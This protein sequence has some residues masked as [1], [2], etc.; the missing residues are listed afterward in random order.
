MDKASCKVSCCCVSALEGLLACSAMVPVI[1][2]RARPGPRTKMDLIDK[3]YG[4]RRRRK[5]MGEEG[6]EEGEEEEEE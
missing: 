3:G 1:G 5:G 2:A 6:K 4:S